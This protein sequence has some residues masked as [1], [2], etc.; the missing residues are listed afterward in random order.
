M[1]DNL[2]AMQDDDLVKADLRDHERLVS[3]RAPWEAVWRAIDER[4]PD[5]AGGFNQAS[6]GA[7]RG[8]ANFDTTHI[9]ALERFK[10]AMRSITTPRDKQ[11]I[12][13]RFSAELMKERRVRVWCQV[14]GERLFGIRHAMHTGFGISVDEDWDQHG[15]YGTSPVWSEGRQG[16][17]LFYRTL[18]LSGSYIDVDFAGLVN[19]HHGKMVKRASELEEMM[20]G[21]EYLTPKMRRALERGGN[22]NAE[23]EIV[24]IVAPNRSWDED[25]IDWRRFPIGSRYL[26]IDEKQYLRR[27]GYHTIP[28]SV[29]RHTTSP[30]EKYGRSIAIK[31]LPTI[32][33]TNAMMHT[34]F[35]AGHKATDPALIFN[36]DDGITSLMTK[37]GGANPGLVSDT[38]Q[39][40]V[41]RMPG[42]ENGIPY[43]LEMIEQQRTVIRTAFLE[44]FYK[45]LT[46]PNSRMTTTE[47]LEVMSKQGILVAPYAERYETEKQLPLT[48]RDLDLAMRAGQ[49]EPFPP[50]VIEAGEWPW[51]DYENELAA[52]ARAQ[53]TAKTLRF[54]EALTP[55]A[56]IDPTIY[57]YLDTDEM[58]PGMA[59]EIGVKPQYVRDAKAV[60]A[61]RQARKESEDA[62]AGVDALAT[63]AGAALDLAKANEIGVAA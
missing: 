55:M 2:T 24:H 63:G 25:R 1:A 36:N 18:H 26:A 38:G 57:D 34:T 9:T 10:A 53:G 11:Y 21:V 59:A 12:V 45:I 6:P 35:R 41:A 32:D 46:D 39:V 13:P 27:G 42:G 4:F 23:F 3:E 29:S 16:I 51:I 43:A 61:I 22:P 50:E 58:V 7:V 60:A 48:N 15:R 31:M 20:G 37:P 49:I 19:R 54:V 52:M 17:G 47:V 28:V 62:T 5:G 8:A 44:E 33:G 40:L 14:A 30:G 56:A